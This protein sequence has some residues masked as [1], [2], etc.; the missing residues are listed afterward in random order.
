MGTGRR[1]ISIQKLQLT[2]LEGGLGAPDFKAY[3]LSAQ[4]QWLSYWAAGRNLQEIGYTSANIT[5]GE[6]H[7]LILPKAVIPENSPSLLRTALRCWKKALI[8][9]CGT[10]PYSKNIPLIGIPTPNR[11]ITKARI[12]EWEETGIDEIGLFFADGTLMEHALFT[13]TTEAPA[14]L[15]LL[16]AMVAHYIKS[17]WAPH[18][19]EPPQHELVHLLYYMGNGAHLVRWF[20]KGLHTHV[21]PTLSPL[22]A[23]WAEDAATEIT[24]KAWDQIIGHPKRVSRNARLKFI[25]SM[26]LHRAYLTPHKI[27]RMFPEAQH[28]FPHC[29]ADEAD[30]LHC[31]GP[32]PAYSIIGII[33]VIALARLH[34]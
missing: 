22:R 32:V 21:A 33:F 15:Y 29:K 25:Q 16:H 34:R 9:T 6:L 8:Y 7:T 14:H 4:L 17:T 26:I 12:R 13:Q 18:C 3:Y 27:H 24:D 1:R 20:Y 5:R 19:T 28:Q 10:V 23:K 30:F 2:P 11:T 31:S